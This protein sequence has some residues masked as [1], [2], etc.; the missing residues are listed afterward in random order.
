LLRFSAVPSGENGRRDSWTQRREYGMML[1]LYH[2]SFLASMNVK[3][4]MMQE[5]LH[6]RKI[7]AKN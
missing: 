2:E 1:Y 7:L 5:N 4:L 3:I 6:L